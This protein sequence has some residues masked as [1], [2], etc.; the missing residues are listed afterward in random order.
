MMNQLA[1]PLIS[2]SHSAPPPRLRKQLD[3]PPTPEVCPDALQFA[4]QSLDFHPDLKQEA[5]LGAPHHRLIL[6]CTRQ[7]GKSTVAAAKAVHLALTKPG[8]LIII[9]APVGRQSGEFIQK[10]QDFVAHLGIRPRGDGRNPNSI[11]LPNRSRLIGIPGSREANIRGFSAVSLLIIDEAARVPDELY[12]AATPMLAVSGGGLWLLS[13]PFSTSGFFYQEWKF[14]HGWTRISVPATECPRIPA[15]FLEDKRSKMGEQRFRREYMCEFHDLDGTLFARELIERCFSPEVH[16]LNLSATTELLVP[17]HFFIGLDLGQ[18]RDFTAIAILQRRDGAKPHYLTP[19][20]VPPTYYDL[21]HLER[22]PLGTP[23]PLIVKKMEEL[24][25]L[26]ILKGRCTVVADGTGV[27]G[28]VVEMLRRADLAADLIPV[29]ITAGEHAARSGHGWNVPR[30]DLL[31][32]LMLTV[33]EEQLRIAPHLPERNR[34]VTEL[35]SVHG[36][37]ARHRHGS[38]HDDLVFALALAAWRAK[39]DAPFGHQNTGRLI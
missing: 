11:L 6:N 32:A 38:E 8:A 10:A 23:Y 33:E 3:P 28:P 22:L 20:I 19:W 14:G 34:L 27:G 18:K 5:I 15:D 4:R 39:H 1:D 17:G 37:A 35:M 21:R 12:H 25:K 9:A 36:G 16:L 30:R 26:P 24:T 13:T 29:T 7:W 31:T 2:I